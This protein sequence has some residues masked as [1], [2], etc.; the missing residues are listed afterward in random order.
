MSEIDFLKQKHPILSRRLQRIKLADL[1]TPVKTTEV[2]VDSRP[3]A[4]SI[5]YDNLT[6]SLYGGNK[7][8]KLE[9]IFPRVSERHCLRVATFGAVG[10]NHALATALYASEVGLECT[11]FLSHQAQTPM[12]APTLNAHILNGTELVR[13]GGAYR[14]RLAILRET[15]WYK[16]FTYHL[17]YIWSS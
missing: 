13:Y 11:C 9:Y 16:F 17:C 14:S 5:K 2:Q 8:R 3:H 12:V 15:L 4:L 10:S 7:V 6:G 1:P